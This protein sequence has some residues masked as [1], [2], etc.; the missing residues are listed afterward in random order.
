MKPCCSVSP[1][2]CSVIT[3]V[4]QQASNLLIASLGGINNS[5]GKQH[6][7]NHG[8]ATLTSKLADFIFS[9]ES[10][11][12]VCVLFLVIN[13]ILKHSHCAHLSLRK[14]CQHCVCCP[15]HLLFSHCRSP[16]SWMVAH[17][18][19]VWQASSPTTALLLHL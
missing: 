19:W 13:G 12:S 4:L 17:T 9:K 18:S 10:V 3:R 11:C 5:E 6:R 7:N 8:C 14:C 1:Y 2:T 16:K 15:R